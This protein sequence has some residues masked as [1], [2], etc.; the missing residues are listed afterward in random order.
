MSLFLS[1]YQEAFGLASIKKEG[2]KERRRSCS[3]FFMQSD[4]GWAK[5]ALSHHHH[6]PAQGPSTAVILRPICHHAQA[7]SLEDLHLSWIYSSEHKPGSPLE[8]IWW[9]AAQWKLQ[10]H[11]RGQHGREAEAMGFPT[12]VSDSEAAFERS[13]LTNPGAPHPQWR[14]SRTPK[15]SP[16]QW[17]L[18]YFGPDHISLRL[19]YFPS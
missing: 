8:D 3:T 15:H 16:G 10:W 18:I 11:R 9:P 4:L 5:L 14:E 7:Q 6:H 13:R 1:T 17:G 12:F 19:G 2:R